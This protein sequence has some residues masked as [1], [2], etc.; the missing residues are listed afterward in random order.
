MI[1]SK[2]TE[3]TL[4]FALLSLGGMV[5]IPGLSL[6]STTTITQT[7]YAQGVDGEELANGIID[8]VFG[9]DE[10]D[11]EEA[12]TSQ[13][14]D[15]PVTQNLTQAVDQSEDNDQSNDNDQ[16]QTGVIDQDTTQGI[17]DGDDKAKSKSES[18]DAKKYSSSSSESG[19]AANINAQAAVNN[20][21]LNQEQHQDV[22]QTNTA[23]FGDDE[24]DLDGVNVAVPIAIPISLQEEEIVEEPKEEVQPPPEEGLFCFFE[25]G[26]SICFDN[27]AECQEALVIVDRGEEMCQRFETLPEDGI[28]CRIN[29]EG[30]IDCPPI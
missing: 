9:A 16:T 3:A 26:G 30:Q 21:E 10:E 18:G 27:L 17:E 14:I 11:E 19:D 28:L 13:T 29:E 6:V 8:D 7:A 2:M 22:T 20:A 25:P 1:N 23:N 15:Q 5:A 12:D 4:L 24:A